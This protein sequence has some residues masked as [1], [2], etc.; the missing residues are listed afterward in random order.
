MTGRMTDSVRYSK[1]NPP[2]YT[3]CVLER[4]SGGES[5]RQTEEEGERDKWES[6]Q[7][8]IVSLLQCGCHCANK[9]TVHH[10]DLNEIYHPGYC[11]C[12]CVYVCF[13]DNWYKNTMKDYVAKGCFS[14][15]VDIFAAQLALTPVV[16]LPLNLPEI[17]YFSLDF[18]LIPFR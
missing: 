6:N 11:M 3:A 8:F 4:A 16:F 10:L 2:V 12:V 15:F 1:L 18:L 7:C 14:G 5:M 17:T 13:V 9:N